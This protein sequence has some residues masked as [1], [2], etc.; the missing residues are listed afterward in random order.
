M[1][2]APTSRSAR[3]DGRNNRRPEVSVPSVDP[4]SWRDVQYLRNVRHNHMQ[5]HFCTFASTVALIIAI[6]AA[7]KEAWPITMMMGLGVIPG[8]LFVLGLARKNYR[9]QQHDRIMFRCMEETEQAAL[10]QNIRLQQENNELLI[11]GAKAL[12]LITDDMEKTEKFTAAIHYLH[13]RGIN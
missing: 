8:V 6:Y 4:D 1:S 3:A 13:G 11:A 10:K 5:A 2:K 7:F 12:G 9:W